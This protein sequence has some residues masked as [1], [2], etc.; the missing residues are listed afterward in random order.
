[1]HEYIQMCGYVH[2][3]TVHIT[4]LCKTHLGPLLIEVGALPVCRSLIIVLLLGSHKNIF[5]TEITLITNLR[6][7]SY[8]QCEFRATAVYIEKYE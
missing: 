2:T 5:H 1:M 3:Y 6:P 4:T 7:P 8:S